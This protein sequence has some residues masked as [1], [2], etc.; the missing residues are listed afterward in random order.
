MRAER[1]ARWV[2]KKATVAALIAWLLPLLRLHAWDLGLMEDHWRT[3][4][5][6]V[7][8]AMGLSALAV[9]AELSMVSDRGRGAWFRFAAALLPLAL[10]IERWGRPT[11]NGVLGCVIVMVVAF[12][13]G[14]GSPS[15]RIRVSAL[16][17]GSVVCVGTLEDVH[18]TGG[19]PL[20]YDVARAFAH[21]YWLQR[22][23]LAAA[24]IGF[25]SALG[26]R[27]TRWPATAGLS[28]ALGAGGLEL[29]GTIA[30][31]QVV[32]GA[33]S[34]GVLP[35]TWSIDELAWT[36]T[37]VEAALMA[38]LVFL[39]VTRLLRV[40]HRRARFD[41]RGT[42]P[43]L[44]L[45][46]WVAFAAQSPVR[47]PL[48]APGPV[49]LAEADHDELRET[50]FY[51]TRPRWPAQHPMG[52][53]AIVVE[54]DGRAFSYYGREPVSELRFA[55]LAR[56]QVYPDGRAPAEALERTLRRLLRQV[57]EVWVAVRRT[58]VRHLPLPGTAARLRYPFAATMVPRVGFQRAIRN[59]EHDS[60][61]TEPPVPCPSAEPG[62]T[63]ATHLTRRPSICVLEPADVDVTTATPLAPIGD[64]PRWHRREPRRPFPLLI[65]A[66]L[67]LAAALLFA[68]RSVARDLAP[69]RGRREPVARP[70]G[71]APV[72]PS[73]LWRREATHWWG[74]SAGPY[75]DDL[76]FL[77]P[78]DRAAASLALRRRAWRILGRGLWRVL[79]G[80]VAL[81][82]GGLLGVL[83]S[84]WI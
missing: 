81:V 68:Q 54:R 67:G 66:L 53:Q 64:L 16:M 65:G 82:V 40:A 3:E 61:T 2:A 38:V 57:P 56:A 62:E 72:R 59:D 18:F 35:V 30:A 10:I 55:P 12:V 15:A 52:T 5:A 48:P 4:V 32:T 58:D 42:V 21:S 13:I 26:S 74:A 19:H 28:L 79:L 71:W 44:V 23:P 7:R 11:E 80:C 50:Q 17:L 60:R 9:V 70:H 1:R 34:N 78:A 6:L 29:L 24:L 49:P 83:G 39:A 41:S 69:L 20:S 25:A 46:A 14:A 51:Y 73:W 36:A 22:I 31:R 33:G 8:C 63:V 43:A 84:M 47:A 77:G 76:G 45:A 27:P 75:R 37:L